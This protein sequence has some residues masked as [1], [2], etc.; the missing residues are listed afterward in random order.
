MKEIDLLKAEKY[1]LEKYKYI[2][3]IPRNIKNN[4]NKIDE[5][6]RRGKFRVYKIEKE[7]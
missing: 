3:K 7:K 1:M 5:K 2:K 4:K 6:F